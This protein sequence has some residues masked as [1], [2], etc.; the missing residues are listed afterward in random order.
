MR[1]VLDFL[2]KPLSTAYNNTKNIGDKKLIVNTEMQNH[3]YVS[4]VGVVLGVPKDS[5]GI[6]VG[7]KV[8]VHHNV[9]RRYRDVRGVE[10][11]SRSYYGDGLFLV[12]PNQIYGYNKS[13]N[14]VACEGFN[15]VKPIKNNKMFSIDFERPFIGILKYKDKNLLE[16]EENDL[17]GFKPGMEY[18]FVI[19]NEKL[20]R[21]PSNQITIKYEYQGDEEE[22]NPSWAQGC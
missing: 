10:K 8:I 15:F 13:N 20:Y 19:D 12:S 7:D 21:V 16:V 18:E 22:Y 4:R 5:M 14:W 1:C 3:N 17:I 9:F 6:S 2:I 11:N